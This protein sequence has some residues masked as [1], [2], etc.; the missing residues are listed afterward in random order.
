S[1][2]LLDDFRRD[3]PTGAER[4]LHH[5]LALAGHLLPET[6]PYAHTDARHLPAGNGKRLLES[7]L[8]GVL[9]GPLQDADVMFPRPPPLVRRNR[10]NGG[11]SAR[12]GTLW[13]FQMDKALT[14]SVNTGSD[15]PTS[16]CAYP[17]ISLDGVKSIP[18]LAHD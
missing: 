3:G 6:L 1:V 16:H 7:L 12:E 11:P 15:I 2:E 8:L 18:Y 14:F 10:Q 5:G 13:G 9:H 17:H 4:M